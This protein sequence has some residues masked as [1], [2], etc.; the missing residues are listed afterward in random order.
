MRHWRTSPVPLIFGVRH[1]RRAR[2]CRRTR[3]RTESD[4]GHPCP[5][6]P[7]S[8]TAPRRTTCWK[9]P[10]AGST[11]T[12]G[13][14]RHRGRH[15]GLGAGR[16]RRPDGDRRRRPLRGLG[17]RRL[18]RG[19]G[20]HRGRG[21]PGQ[22]QAQDAGVRRR[23]RDRLAGGPAVRRPDQGVRRAAGEERGA[24]AAHPRDRRPHQPARPGGAHAPGRR[25]PRGVRA[26]RRAMPTTTSAST[27]RAARAS[28]RR[29]RTAR[30]SCTPWCRRP[31]S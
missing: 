27:S 26:R 1:V 31:A 19:R 6:H 9:P 23:R 29:R 14:A 2:L 5:S 15:L 17:L 3:P 4:R 8:S 12:A 10:A 21:H 22:R 20:D 28:S 24:A 18:R 16:R 30:C 13:R 25:P 11:R 7:L